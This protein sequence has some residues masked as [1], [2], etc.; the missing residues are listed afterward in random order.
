MI[1]RPS[2][3]ALER[4]GLIKKCPVDQK[5]IENLLGRAETDLKTARRN[6]EDDPECAHTFAYRAMLRSGQALMLSS[7]YRPDIK[8]K[9]KTVVQ[10]AGAVLSEEYEPVVNDFDQIRRKRHSFFYEP[11]VPCSRMEAEHALKT[12][13]SFLKTVRTV[14]Q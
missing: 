12:A 3:E 14:M 10:F 4:Q 11:E 9:H 7:G 5:A 8:N 6:L 2:E 1:S 13:A